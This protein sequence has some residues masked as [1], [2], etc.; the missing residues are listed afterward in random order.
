MLPTMIKREHGDR[1]E[2]QR[3]ESRRTSRSDQAG[4]RL[5][6]TS[7]E[8]AEMYRLMKLVHRLKATRKQAHRYLDLSRRDD[9]FR[10]AA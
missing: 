9:R 2:N 4:R 6:L 10:K 5:M 3:R 1:D 8:R 7:K